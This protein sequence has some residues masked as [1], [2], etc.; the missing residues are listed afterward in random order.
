MV[1][2]RAS[3]LGY[4]QR[5][6]PGAKFNGSAGLLLQTSGTTTC[7]G[8]VITMDTTGNAAIS[9]AAHS[10]SAIYAGARMASATTGGTAV[11]VSFN[12][13]ADTNP[14][15][16]I[17][18]LGDTAAMGGWTTGSAKPLTWVLSAGTGGNWSGMGSLPPNTSIQY[19]YIKKDAGGNVVWKCGTNRVLTT[20]AGGTSTSTNDVWKE[21]IRK[22]GL[23]A[24][25]TNNVM[26]C[27]F[28]LCISN[29]SVFLLRRYNSVF[30][31]FYSGF[32]GKLYV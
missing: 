30:A 4:F 23:S 6:C 21:T 24:R 3:R 20:G 12:E 7:T 19:K 14:G 29:L 25:V 1:M 18:I 16:N 10:T 8:N 5:S 28:Y 26:A 13:A 31:H 15:Q 11:T 22:L 9:V 32:F 17:F 27:A 2:M